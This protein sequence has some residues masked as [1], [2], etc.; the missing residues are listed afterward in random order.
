MSSKFYPKPA[1]FE[2]R[3][4]VVPNSLVFSRE[5]T[6]FAKILILALNAIATSAPH[7]VPIQSDLEKRLGWGKKR[8]RAAIKSCEECG[9]MKVK[10]TRCMEDIK[11]ENGKSKKGQWKYNDFEFDT[12][13]SFL[14]NSENS[15]EEKHAHIQCEPD[16]GKGHAP[17]GHALKESLIRNYVNDINNNIDIKDVRDCGNVHNSPLPKKPLTEK[18]YETLP[19][20]SD[21]SFLYIEDISSASQNSSL[22]D[23]YIEFIN[24]FRFESG[25]SISEKVQLRWMRTYGFEEI[26]QAILHFKRENLKKVKLKP[27]AYIESSLKNQYWKTDLL[28]KKA[29]QREVQHKKDKIYYTKVPKIA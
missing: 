14:E 10:Q 4:Q 21:S 29:D 19:Q 15:S 17:K 2:S 11:D 13:P 27:E 6:D 12:Y 8:M 26:V 25:N 24:K 20:S 16:A 9:Y 22:D 7:W 5:L 23:R 18:S 28:R 1:N 3:N